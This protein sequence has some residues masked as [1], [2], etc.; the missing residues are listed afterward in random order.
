L[1]VAEPGRFDGPHLIDAAAVGTRIALRHRPKLLLRGDLASPDLRKR[2]GDA[3]ILLPAVANEATGIDI[4]CIWMS[5]TS[6]LLSGEDLPARTGALR[7]ALAGL[8]ADLID[9]TDGLAMFELEGAAAADVLAAS[10]GVDFSP[11]RFGPGRSATTLVAGIVVTICRPGPA[12]SYELYV[13]TSHAAYLED[14]LA[15]GAADLA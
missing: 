10:G 11:D 14:W 13:D 7:A 15:E 4:R 9:I 1:K 2:L 5:P 8:H 12:L 6:C 3:G